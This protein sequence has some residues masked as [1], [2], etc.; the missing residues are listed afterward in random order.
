MKSFLL[1][2]L[3]SLNVCASDNS[4]SKDAKDGAD[5]T[6]TELQDSQ[7]QEILKINAS[8]LAETEG[9]TPAIWVQKVLK[10]LKGAFNY[11]KTDAEKRRAKD[12]RE[13]GENL[14]LLFSSIIFF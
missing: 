9:I 12:F 7:R 8:Q 6:F 14:A 5:I 1:V 4:A 3:I 11:L 10:E 13:N 2:C